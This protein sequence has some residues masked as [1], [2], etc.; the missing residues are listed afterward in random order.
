MIINSGNLRTLGTGFKANFQ[1]G[2]GMA[3]PDHL[4]IATEITSTTGKEEYGWLGQVPGMREW[5]GDRVVQN[6][7]THDYT[8][9]NRDFEL[10]IAVPR[11]NIQDDNIGMYG[12]LF[13]EMG[14][15][16]TAHPSQLC[17]PLMKAGFSTPCYDGQYFFDTDHPVLDENGV[18]VSVANTNGGNG[19]AW[20]LFDDTRP[21]KPLIFQK[22][23]APD[24]QAKDDPTDENVWRRKEFEY[25]VD[26]RY[27]GGF[28]FW[29]FCYGSRQP[30]TPENY[31]AARAALL[32][33]KGDYG[34]P[35]GITPT[36]LLVS[37]TLEGAGKRIVVN[38]KLEGGADN[39]WAGTAK[40]VV[41]PWLA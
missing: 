34:R 40:L 18:E 36:T 3:K 31:E 4:L 5:L 41:S 32:N 1:Q 23:K 2:L 28:G 27:N 39:E 12:P 20:F 7:A 16:T 30:L 10:T 15:A 38:T 37:P 26:A 13:Q 21:L 29:Q 22:R 19:A 14:R 33:M 11:N 6:I 17:Y 8:I 35:L 25:G 24:F 9:K